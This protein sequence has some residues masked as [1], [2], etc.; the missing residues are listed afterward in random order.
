MVLA[1]AVGAPLAVESQ[2]CCIADVGAEG[3]RGVGVGYQANILSDERRRRYWRCRA[4]QALCG[5]RGASARRWPARSRPFVSCAIESSAS[6]A[7]P[8]MESSSL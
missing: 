1:G 8:S 4:V 2:C 6:I 5:A 7:R 3:C